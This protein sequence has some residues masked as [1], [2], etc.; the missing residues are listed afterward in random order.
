MARWAAPQ[1]AIPRS[2]PSRRRQVGM[3][4]CA[5]A[6]DGGDR[7]EPSSRRSTGGGSERMVCGRGTA[8]YERLC[9]PVKR[10]QRCNA[11]R[12][13]ASSRH[14]RLDTTLGASPES[15]HG[16]QDADEHRLMQH[17]EAEAPSAQHREGT[18]PPRK[19]PRQPFPSSREHPLPGRHPPPHDAQPWQHRNIVFRRWSMRDEPCPIGEA[20]IEEW[21]V[22]EPR[23]RDRDRAGHPQRP[24]QP[25]RQPHHDQHDCNAVQHAKADEA[26][27]E[28]HP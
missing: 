21:M 22:E 24:A 6:A 5:G 26:V 23:K 14:L 19:L 4:R 20:G 15:L 3:R 28:H 11:L 12:E 16:H 10:F 9:R 13:Q 27:L 8:S 17:V 1:R 7:R 18:K 2:T 25:R